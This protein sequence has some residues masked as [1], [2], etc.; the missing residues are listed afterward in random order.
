MDFTD[1]R[2]VKI[3]GALLLLAALSQPLYTALYMTAPEVSRKF[4]WSFEAFIFV[5]ML[6][7]AGA[8]LV[9]S[10][11]LALGFS[12]IA[13]S[14][15]L[16]VIQVGVG[17][18]QFG[19]VRAAAQLNSDLG[20]VAS[21]VVGFSFF[22]YNAAKMLLGFAAVVFGLAIVKANSGSLRKALGGA[23]VVVGA[24]AFAANA[25][26]MMLGIQG[27]VPRPLAGGTGVLAALFLGLCLLSLKPETDAV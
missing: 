3:I 15:V 10:K 8:A 14:A 9:Q 26:V 18:T 11:R 19:P 17:L 20:G 22:G 21:S 16:N 6:P 5:L 13:F 12:A 4:I 23:A 7:F 27:V 1:R 25:L 2:T 24:A